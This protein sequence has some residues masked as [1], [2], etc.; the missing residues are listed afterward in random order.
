MEGEDRSRLVGFDGS[1][2]LDRPAAVGCWWNTTA[3]GTSHGG[4]PGAPGVAT[5]HQHTL[6]DG[7]NGH[8]HGHGHRRSARLAM[9]GHAVLGGPPAR[10]ID[11]LADLAALEAVLD[12]GGLPALRNLR[13]DFA[14]AYVD[15]SLSRLVLFRSLTGTRSIYYAHGAGEALRWASDVRRLFAT[16]PGLDDVDVAALPALV[17]ALDLDPARFC[18][19][20]VGRLP[21]G[22]A[23]VV[24]GGCLRHVPPEDFAVERNGDLSLAEGAARLAE[25]IGRAADRNLPPRGSLGALMSGGLDSSI[26]AW[27]ARQGG[28]AVT[29]FHWTWPGLATLAQERAACEAVADELGIPLALVDCMEALGPGGDYLAS[30]RASPVPF[31]HS[32]FRCLAGTAEAAAAG[33]ISAVATGHLGDALFFTGAPPGPA[34]RGPGREGPSWWRG[35]PWR[36]PRTAITGPPRWD[37]RRV[38]RCAPWLTDQATRAASEAGDFP[39]PDEHVPP[40]GRPAYVAVKRNL[41]AGGELRT[42]AL[43]G[44]FLPARVTLHHPFADRDLI[45][46]ALGL[47][48]RHRA[49]WYAGLPLPKVALRAAYLERLPPVVLRRES[50]SPY[51]AVAQ[52]FT[53]RNGRAVWDL[54]G[55][56]SVLAGLGVVDPPGLR[57]VLGD[58]KLRAFCSVALIR[59]A[60]V[61]YWLRGLTGTPPN[62]FLAHEG[63][64]RPACRT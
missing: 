25:L 57:Q 8:E 42:G 40:A 23:L 16:Q 61:E 1:Y 15:P 46:F 20:H 29:G 7:G 36:H 54:L 32:F 21:S 11:F 10:R 41:D 44:V 34:P 47:G 33:G 12:D 22:H 30:M 17:T 48:D 56:R 24:E 5:I 31:N 63:Q 2:P 58:E 6:G 27:E 39:Y 19:R 53:R 52:T 64:E 26:A 60:G 13:G 51:L 4:G 9:A 55:P 62:E 35:R 50:R 45:E 59:A 28:R 14:L 18:Y 3:V 49:A 43:D 37:E 38:A